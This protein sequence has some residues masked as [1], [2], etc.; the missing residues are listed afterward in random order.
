MATDL[1]H[2]QTIREAIERALATEREASESVA[3]C[4]RTATD[5]V[6]EAREA[7]QRIRQRAR[8]RVD[9]LHEHHG[10]RREKTIT[11]HL[12]EG[13]RPPKKPD[14][15]LE[16]ERLRHAIAHLAGFLSGDEQ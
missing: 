2:E 9:F 5:Q 11:A 15:R 14:R 16:E 1:S 12:A 13:T 8:Q 6:N 10:N 3:A 4:E 7:A